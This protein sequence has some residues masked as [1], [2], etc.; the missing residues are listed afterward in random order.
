M[1]RYRL[2]CVGGKQTDFKAVNLSAPVLTWREDL[3]LGET[4]VA[5]QEFLAA[6]LE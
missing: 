3:C 5:S 2:T 1:I 6:R 4:E